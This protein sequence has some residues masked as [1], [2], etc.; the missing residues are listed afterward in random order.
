MTE[1]KNTE[2]KKVLKSAHQNGS[3]AKNL[4]V[5]LS[6][7]N[8]TQTDRLDVDHHAAD[9]ALDPISEPLEHSE[10]VSIKVVD[11]VNLKQQDVVEQ[12]EQMGS[13][14]QIQLKQMRDEVVARTQI[15]RQQVQYS[16]QHLHTLRTT[17]QAELG[18]LW[19]DLNKFGIELKTDITQLSLKHRLQLTQTIKKSTTDTLSVWSGKSKN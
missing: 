10:N 8:A 19:R 1:Q 12:A 6:T 4:Q 7:E 13:A 5:K 3:Q 18:D 11:I 9:V 15:L 17:L 16:Q 14:A 2:S